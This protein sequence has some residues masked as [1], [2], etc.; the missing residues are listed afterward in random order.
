MRDRILGDVPWN[1]SGHF[2]ETKYRKQHIPRSRWPKTVA[3][4]RYCV[5]CGIL[6]TRGRI[7][8]SVAQHNRRKYCSRNC[9]GRDVRGLKVAVV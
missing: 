2:K 5:K 1:Y 3:E 6:I 9:Y 8:E 7:N 4:E